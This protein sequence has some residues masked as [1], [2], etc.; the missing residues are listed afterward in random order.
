MLRAVPVLLLDRKPFHI[1]RVHDLLDPLVVV[2]DRKSRHFVEV[3]EMRLVAIAAADKGIRRI[4]EG[5]TLESSVFDHVHC[6]FFLS[7]LCPIWARGVVK[8][9]RAQEL[10][11][12]YLGFV[13]D[14]VLDGTLTRQVVIVLV[15][16][17]RVV[18]DRLLSFSLTSWNKCLL[19]LLANRLS[20]LVSDDVTVSDLLV[21]RRVVQQSARLGHGRFILHR[22]LLV[23]IAALTALGIAHV[24]RGRLIAEDAIVHLLQILVWA[25]VA[26]TYIACGVADD[27]F[28]RRDAMVLRAV[29]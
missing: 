9:G 10:A 21:D 29:H 16:R 18:L 26:P 1:V 15:H 4:L 8:T 6:P 27:K 25:V 24:G 11:S 5:V 2:Q 23:Q 13:I 7:F 14:V 22:L 3:F 12:N 19:V 20:K 28:V 17:E